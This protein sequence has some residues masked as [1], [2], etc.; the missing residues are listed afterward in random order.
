MV[1]LIITGDLREENRLILM[2]FDESVHGHF[3]ISIMLIVD[4]LQE[5]KCVKCL[6]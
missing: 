4:A 1:T 2:Y 3:L 6:H 5:S